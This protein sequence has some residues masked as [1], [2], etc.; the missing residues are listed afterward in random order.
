MHYY[1]TVPILRMVQYVQCIKG[2]PFRTSSILHDDNPRDDLQSYSGYHQPSSPLYPLALS[3]QPL[4]LSLS[5]W[6]ITFHVIFNEEANCLQQLAIQLLLLSRST[7]SR[8]AGGV[9]LPLLM[10][11]INR[12]STLLLSQQAATAVV[13][14]PPL[15][16]Y[17]QNNSSDLRQAVVGYGP[18]LCRRAEAAP[19]TARAHGSSYAVPM[20]FPRPELRSR[21]EGL[22][23]PSLRDKA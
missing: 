11:G 16:C 7:R 12:R 15:D 8:P 23:K 5:S 1:R 21:D 13:R 14:L 22:R 17:G 9:V 6:Q 2:L 4:A 20:A 10:R 3:V 19:A 18:S